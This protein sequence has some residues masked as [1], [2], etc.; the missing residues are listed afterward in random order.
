MHRCIVVVLLFLFSTTVSANRKQHLD[1]LANLP[2]HGIEVEVR[3]WQTLVK[4]PS[5]RQLQELVIKYATY[6]DQGQ[7]DRSL[8]QAGWKIAEKPE[9]ISPDSLDDFNPERFKPQL[10]EYEVLQKSLAAL[11]NWQNTA[12]EHFPDDLILFEGDQH[13]AIKKLNRWL[14]DLDLVEN[15]PEDEYR[16]EHKDALTQVQVQFDLLPDGRL[17]ANTRQALLSVTNERI[18]ILKAN[19]ERVRWLP[20]KLPYPHIR[21]DIAGFNVAWVEAPYR[22][23]LYRAIVGAPHKQTPIFDDEIEGI[24]FNP[25]WKVPHSIAAKSLLRAEK[26]KPGFLRSE[27][28]VVYKNW[29]DNAPV[30]DMD[31]IDWAKVTTRNFRYRLEQQPGEL[32]RLGYYKLNLPNQYGVY[33][34]DTDKPKLFDKESRSFSSGCTRV[35]DINL[36]IKRMRTFQSPF[37]NTDDDRAQSADSGQ[38][39]KQAFSNNIPIYFIYFTAWPD[40]EGRVRFRKDIYQ[41]DKALVGWY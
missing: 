36:L 25:T 14:I 16:Q 40:N 38:T 1:W 24:T 30:I 9:F 8:Y 39:Y 17:G 29:D 22:Q 7:L 41:Q 3:D 26:K 37:V 27:G 15:L 23:F 19:L 11:R 21:V 35:Q 10:P 31:T 32:N 34:H 6:L 18:R 4:N 20:A 33:L 13:P 5:S 28:F 2:E 12:S